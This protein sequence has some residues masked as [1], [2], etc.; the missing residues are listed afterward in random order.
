[1]TPGRPRG[2][3]PRGAGD[4][5]NEGVPEARLEL[6]LR[7]ARPKPPGHETIE[8]ERRQATVWGN[9]ALRGG[10]NRRQARRS[11]T[12]D[13]DTGTLVA[14]G[15]EVIE[16]ARSWFPREEAIMTVGEAAWALGVSQTTVYGYI[17]S[18]KLRH[19][20][21]DGR[22]FLFERDVANLNARRAS[23]AYGRRLRP[24]S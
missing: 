20:K 4:T 17:R 18:G 8:A 22:Y 5:I 16:S 9:A 13:S 2:P 21:H 6:R 3:A 19:R 7:G 23:E 10:E 24:R 15:S 12:V 11:R 14:V 1:V